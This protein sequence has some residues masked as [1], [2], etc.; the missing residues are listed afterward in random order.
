MATI[1][2]GKVLAEKIYEELKLE[3]DKLKKKPALAVVLV[4]ED[5]A[6]QVYVNIKVKT[7]KKIG[8][9]SL[10]HKL[11]KDTSQEDLLKLVDKLNNNPDVNGILVQMPAPP[12]IDDPLIMKSVLP[13]KDVD[14]FH[15]LNIGKMVLGQPSLQPCTP[16]GVMEM[17]KA[18]DIDLKGKEVVLIGKS[19]IVGRPML[20]L[21]LSANATVTTCHSKTKDLKAHT[22]KAD[23]VVAAA[24]YP[25]LVTA[26]MVKEGVVI[27]DIGTTKV[28]GKLKGDVEYEPVKEK[29]SFITPV[30]GGVGPMTVACLMKNTLT[31]YKQQNNLEE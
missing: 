31:A 7:C 14:G 24:G 15:P 2:D 11:D 20:E 17:F 13:E 12:Q 9:T 6:S 28:D 21:M 26:D 16:M 10:M 18:Y 30:P 25:G 27:I 4:G 23:I 3:V 19:V 1:I 29:A 5:P 8:I 22:Q